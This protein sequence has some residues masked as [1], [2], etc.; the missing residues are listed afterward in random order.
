MYNTYVEVVLQVYITQEILLRDIS[1]QMI[2]S[3]TP[4]LLVLLLLYF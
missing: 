2:V 4:F 3:R 1:D